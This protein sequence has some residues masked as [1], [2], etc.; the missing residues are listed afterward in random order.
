[1]NKKEILDILEKY[2]LNNKEIIIISGAAMVLR[3]LKE[4]TDDIDIAISEKY[5]KEL[6]ESFD[7]QFEKEI[8]DDKKYKTYFIDNI[9]NFSTH[10]YDKY[11]GES[12]YGY[13][14][15]KV[16]DILELKQ[17]LNRDK[18]QEA[19][20]KIQKFI[21]LKNT[22][23]LVLAYMGDSVYEVY[24]RKHLISSGITKVNELQ[25]ESI[26]FVSAKAQSEILDKLLEKKFFSEEE[27]NIIKRARNH[28]S[29]P[30]KSTNIVSYKKSTGFEAL[31]GYLYLT[32]N[33]KRIYDIIDRI[34]GGD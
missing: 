11:S 25:K 6:L 22:N 7:C 15:Q 9:I 17:K 20:K 27:E 32:G 29:H 8:T 14:V 4:K 33:N 2:N 28:K 23:S 30:S 10:Y 24:I 26:K 5:E 1:M 3:G 31:I 13:K 18:D 16:E 19:I 12:L 21:N 34:T